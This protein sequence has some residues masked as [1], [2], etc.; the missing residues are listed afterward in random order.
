MNQDNIKKLIEDTLNNLTVQFDMVEFVEDD[1]H[2]IFMIKTD[3]SGVLIG[4]NGENLRALNHVI[5]KIAY[6]KTKTDDD[7][8]NQFIV[9]VNGYNRRRM[10]E[11]KD[12]AAILAERARLFKSSVEMSPMNAYERMIVHSLLSDDNEIQTQSEGEGRFRRVVLKYVV[13]ES[14]TVD[15]ELKV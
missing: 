7:T 8:R 6:T 11:I 3:D 12:Q 9:D 1:V 5:K 2:P 10:K 13:K 15:E 14:T 4:N